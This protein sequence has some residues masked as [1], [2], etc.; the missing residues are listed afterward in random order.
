MKL[1]K[2]ALGQVMEQTRRKP[3]LIEIQIFFAD[4]VRIMNDHPQTIL[5]DQPNDFYPIT[6]SS[7]LGQQL[8]PN[9]L[10][11][12]LHNQ[13]DLCKDYLYNSTL[14]HRFW[15]LCRKSYISSFQG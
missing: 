15:L 8:A 11:C 14:A 13:G 10:L 1:F 12:G 2:S 7:F 5:S 4:A 6:P 3:F 9:T